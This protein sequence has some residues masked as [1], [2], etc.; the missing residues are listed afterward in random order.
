M[1]SE[2]PSSDPLA[3][4]R[5][6]ALAES[7]TAFFSVVRDPPTPEAAS[8]VSSQPPERRQPASSLRK[9]CCSI[10][11]MYMLRENEE[12]CLKHLATELK[13]ERRRVYDI[14]NI[15]EAFDILA[16][17]AKNVYVWRGLEEFRGKL[18]VLGVSAPA[19]CP[20]KV[21]NFEHRPIKSK[22]K[23][24][25]YMSLRV[26]RFFGQ[27]S[28]PINFGEIVRL[29]LCSDSQKDYLSEKRASTTRR[30]YDIVNVL[31]ALGLI[32]KTY[33]EQHK[34]YYKWNG[35]EG[36][37][38]QLHAQYGKRLRP[39]RPPGSDPLS[40]QLAKAIPFPQQGL[41]GTDDPGQK[42]GENQPAN[43]TASLPKGFQPCKD[44]GR[45]AAAAG[46]LKRLLSVSE[47][48]SST[49]KSSTAI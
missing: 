49:G 19:L 46:G 45:L 34:K 20:L 4:D 29:C 42:R 39:E 28:Q 21:F 17:K 43:T 32:S 24:L 47:G 9:I 48:E 18:V 8:P 41:G 10:L 30:L 26:L 31:N 36:M 25:T 23:M 7:K 2:W 5:L 14:V 33:D 13:T 44:F 27:Q 37:M 11:S 3:A 16:K 15:L 12:I 22:K 1:S 35:I 40:F 38:G 6:L